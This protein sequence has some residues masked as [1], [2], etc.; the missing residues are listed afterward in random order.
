MYSPIKKSIFKS[1]LSLGY[2]I[3]IGVPIMLL[4]YCKDKIAL[5]RNMNDVIFNDL[6]LFGL[7]KFPDL[8]PSAEVKALLEDF[9]NLKRSTAVDVSGQ[10]SGRIFS[11]GILSPLLGKYAEI[12]KPH[13]IKFFNTERVKVEISYYQE[14]YPQKDLESVPGGDFHVDDNKANLK[15]FIYLSDVNEESGPFSCVPST[16]SWKLRNSILRGVL[17]E[18]TKNRKY[19]YDF[20]ISHSGCSKNEKKILGI[21]GT[22]FLVDTTSIHKASPVLMGLRRVAVIS[23]NRGNQMRQNGGKG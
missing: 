5:N 20:L 23:F 13:A 18:L 3:S 22:H 10:L 16:G 1:T 19:L 17:W 6:R 2:A 4:G 9:E 7:H 14:S 12:I 15:Y 8:V 11:N 21:S